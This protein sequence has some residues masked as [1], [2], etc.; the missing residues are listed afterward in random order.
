MTDRGSPVSFVVDGVHAHDV[1][2]DLDQGHRADLFDLGAR[3]QGDGGR[4]L[5]DALFKTGGGDHHLLQLMRLVLRVRGGI[6]AGQG[7]AGD[8]QGGGPAKPGRLA[9]K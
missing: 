4:R 8:H 5:F 6:G 9:T 7:R 2:Q 3:D 1:G